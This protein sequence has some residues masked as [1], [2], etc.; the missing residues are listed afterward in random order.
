V[1]F[2]ALRLALGDSVEVGPESFGMSW[3]GKAECAKTIQR[4]SV[5][6]LLPAEDESVDWGTTQ[7]VIIEGDNLEVLKVLQKAYLG[8]VK[9]IYIDPPYNTGNDFIYPD[10][11]AESLQTYLEYSGQTDGEGRKYSTNAETSG[12]YHSKW[13]NMMYPRLAMSRNLLREDGVIFVS[14]NDVE[15]SRLRHI[16]D[17]VFGEENLVAQIPWQ[18]R[19]SVQ[20]DTD[21]SAQHEYIV[22]YAKNR[23]KS[24]RRLKESNFTKWF[25][26]QTFAVLPNP[27][28]PTRFANPDDDPRGPWKADPFD[29]PNVRP[30]L[31]YAITNP[32]TGEEHWPPKGRC[33][34]TEEST[35]RDLLSQERIV[36]G[37]SGDSRP[38]LK[39]F[40]EEKKI[41][42]EVP[43]TWFSGEK[44]GTTSSGTA[45]LEKL[46][47]TTQL[48][49]F[50]KPTSLL[51]TLLQM[52][53]RND[54][55]ILDFFAGSGS[56]GHAVIK[57]NELDG[58]SRR[59]ILVQLPE[60]APVGSYAE[61][62]GFATIAEITKERMRR[63][64]NSPSR[65][66]GLPTN[67][68]VKNSGFRVFRLER[69]NFAVWDANAIEGDETK[70]E[71][72]LFSQVEQVLSDRTSQD[73]LFEL[74]LKSRY[75]LTT[76]VEQVKV[77]DCEVWKVA[78]G[79]MVA[80]ID[81]GLTVE[82]IREIAT[83][84]PLS[85]V[86]LDRSFGADDSLKSNARKIFE[87]EK[88]DLKTV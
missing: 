44:V 59:F 26:E 13:L 69:S 5:A 49:P 40:Y 32:K 24:D 1:N 52:A 65:D 57:Q 53:T 30:N 35:F 64:L 84:K 48:F 77:G 34:R 88:I 67:S 51:Q 55:L 73:I 20:N 31:T 50:P 38:Q 28:D 9:M 45:D 54:D 36:F 66:L 60:P 19:T 2:D 42:G 7:N 72:Q 78:A 18:A 10:T 83:W 4:Q 71:H 25:L 63:V 81:S 14:I 79:E 15:V 41:F 87:D 12:R 76:P 62:N 86:I 61:A 21:L 43:T 17:E 23:R 47:G 6:T 37:K 3:P 75:E 22:A 56:M 58:A 16:C 68:G 11:F 33:W 85:V 74:M 82:V 27:S 70:L 80:I 8:K 39:V 29:A 46:F